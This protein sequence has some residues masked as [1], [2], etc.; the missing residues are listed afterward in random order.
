MCSSYTRPSSY[1]I[2]VGLNYDLN[3]T[4]SGSGQIYYKSLS[5]DMD[6]FKLA[7]VYVNLLD[8]AFVPSQIFIITYDNV[9]PYDSY[10]ISVTSFQIYLSTDSLK[11]YVTFVYNS[12]PTGLTLKASSGLNHRNADGTLQ[13][14]NII[15]GLQ[16]RESNVE[17]L[18][19][20]VSE[21]TS[22]VSG[23]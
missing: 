23:K 12:C 17:Q 9:L 16:C 7:E 4:K 5:S 14:V 20:W 11:S 8:A 15:D 2:L 6:E 3:P 18:G 1:D 22:D 13:E 21:V 19:V 10:S